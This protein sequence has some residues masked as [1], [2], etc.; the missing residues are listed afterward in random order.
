[1]AQDNQA[2]ECFDL[3]GDNITL[4]K[5]K[6]LVTNNYNS[7]IGDAWNSIY[8]TTIFSGESNKTYEAEFKIITKNSSTSAINIGIECDQWR[9]L[10][11]NFID[12]Y[13]NPDGEYY[14]YCSN[15]KKYSHE[16]GCKYGKSFADSFVNNDTICM[17]LQFISGVDYGLLYFKKNDL[18]WEDTHFKIKKTKKIRIAV[19]LRSASY[20]DGGQSS[21]ELISFSI[22]DKYKYAN[23]NNDSKSDNE[24]PMITIHDQECNPSEQSDVVQLKMQITS[25]KEQLNTKQGK[26]VSLEKQNH[27]LR[28]E[29]DK[30]QSQLHELMQ[31]IEKYKQN[32][33]EDK[34]MEDNDSKLE[35]LEEYNI[36]GDLKCLEKQL[37]EFSVNY[38]NNKVDKI[39]DKSPG[40][41]MV[42]DEINAVDLRLKSFGK[43]L[44]DIKLY[45]N[46]LTYPDITKYKKWKIMTV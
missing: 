12:Q 31:Q 11:S 43:Y 41:L 42:N 32:E 21:L 3:I 10:N 34:K 24:T 35:V 26:C 14:A 23:N 45:I 8:G 13:S 28:D 22:S 27:L 38:D 30:M 19:S 33:S 15:G 9:N 39:Y 17:K 20:F 46:T 4:D 16:D 44:M 40:S 5:N 25:L 36:K 37:S 1:M 7:W 18:K 2:E 29:R 6:K